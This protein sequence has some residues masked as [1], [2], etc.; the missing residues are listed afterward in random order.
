MRVT[1]AAAR[2]NAGLTQ[3]EASVRIGVGLNT[4]VDWEKYRKYPN[5]VQAEQLCNLYGCNYEDVLIA[6]NVKENFTEN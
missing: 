3:K 6:N 4:I 2:K 1:W 5:V